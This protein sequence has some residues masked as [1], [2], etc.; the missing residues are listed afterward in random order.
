LG[1]TTDLPEVASLALGSASIP[2]L[3]MTQAYAVL[4]NGGYEVAP[5]AIEKITS[6]DGKILY[7]RK[8]ARTRQLL[9]Q[10]KSF[11][12]THLMTGMF[13]R[14]LNSYIEVTGSS[15][16]D[17]LHDEYAGK[18]GTTNS[19]SWMIGYS[20]KLVTGVWTGYDDNR[21]LTRTSD[22]ALAKQTWA[23][24]M[25]D[26]HADEEER[27]SFPQPENIIGKV[28][29]VESGLLATENCTITR[30]TY[31]EAGT[32]PTVH[33]SN[34][35]A[36]DDEEQLIEDHDNQSFLKKVFDLLP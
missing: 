31:F 14:L 3:E 11:L 22:K 27:L 5:F 6:E 28:I 19:D 29:D 25:Q 2:L 21:P 8:K 26:Y 33:C 1:I 36:K 13:D 15:I 12:L 9:D 4:A 7:E 34:H 30:M 17:D 20:P 23:S 10:G 24:I 35:I 32:E 18:S 16:I